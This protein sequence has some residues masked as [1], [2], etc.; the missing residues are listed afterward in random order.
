VGEAPG[1]G[2]VK[3]S[4]FTYGD[5]PVESL[6]RSCADH[7]GPVWL[8]APEGIAATMLET[9]CRR[10]RAG[11]GLRCFVAPFLPQDQYDLL[12]WACDVNF[13]RGEDSFVRA[14]WAARPF[15]WHVYPTEDNAHYVKL[16]AF[17]ARY[18]AGL[19][20]AQ[21]AAFTSL[22]EAWNRR[23]ES[24]SGEGHAPGFPGA[25][26]QFAARRQ[27]LEAHARKWSASLAQR[28]DLAAE[29]VDFVDNVL[30]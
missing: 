19:D 29:I 18:T 2:T 11:D 21:A 22:W 16:S 15:V 14:Q 17:L 26:A 4:L 13:V 1:E 9:W 28:A 27:A 23:Q 10:S 7:P 5:A 8:V 12:L 3:V 20:R 24:P 25:W 30:K 6:V